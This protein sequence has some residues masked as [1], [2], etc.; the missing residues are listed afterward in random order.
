[1]HYD[2]FPRIT[3][4][5]T[6][7]LHSKH[8]KYELH[9]LRYST[10]LDTYYLISDYI[11]LNYTCMTDRAGIYYGTIAF[12]RDLTRITVSDIKSEWI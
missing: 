5:Q 3:R 2:T 8:S 9:I 7:L 1:M 12:Y 6:I 10:F 11:T 4:L